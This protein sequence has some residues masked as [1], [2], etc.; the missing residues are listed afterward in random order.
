MSILA[1]AKARY[2]AAPVNRHK[3]TVA[4]VNAALRQAGAK[5]RLRRGRGYYYFCDGEA[6]GWPQSGVYVNRVDAMTVDQWLAEWKRM[7][8]VA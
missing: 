4:S 2:E 8:G 1:Q 5:E 3:V 7:G 6:S